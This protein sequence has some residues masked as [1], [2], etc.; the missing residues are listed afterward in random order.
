M[1]L[2]SFILPLRIDNHD[3]IINLKTSLRFL[4]KEF[5]EAEIILVEHDS[6]SKCNGEIDLNGIHY[7]FDCNNGPFS[8][9][10]RLITACYMQK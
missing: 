7:V 1:S 10:M 6:H 8:R 2:L 4:K 5:G 9:V 3:R